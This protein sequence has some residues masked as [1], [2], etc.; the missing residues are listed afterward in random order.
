MHN[1]GI[2]QWKWWR[3][4]A[5]C[6]SVRF[7]RGVTARMGPRG[8]V[9]AMVATSAGDS[10]RQILDFGPKCFEPCLI[11]RRPNLRILEDPVSGFGCRSDR[12]G[13][14]EPGLET[15]QEARFDNTPFHARSLSTGTA[16]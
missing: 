13:G 16:V 6:S 1:P 4:V 10:V 7:S 15:V 12:I 14:E 2:E 9:P 5:P 8:S 3:S 11:N